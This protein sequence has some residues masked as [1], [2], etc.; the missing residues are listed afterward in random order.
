MTFGCKVE[1]ERKVDG[2]E[3]NRD[4]DDRKK[5]ADTG[6]RTASTSFVAPCIGGIEEPTML[7]TLF[8]EQRTQVDVTGLVVRDS[9][10][11]A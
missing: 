4:E 2:R 1:V 10:I 11:V 8:R 5:K 6:A 3:C 7:R 9:W